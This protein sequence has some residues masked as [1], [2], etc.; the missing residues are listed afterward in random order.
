MWMI[1][2]ANIYFVLLA[3]SHANSGHASCSWHEMLSCSTAVYRAMQQTQVRLR[4]ILLALACVACRLTTCLP[5]DN[6]LSA[7]LSGTLRCIN[8][9]HWVLACWQLNL[10]W[11]QPCQMKPGQLALQSGSWAW[12]FWWRS[13]QATLYHKHVRMPCCIHACMHVNK[14]RCCWMTWCCKCQQTLAS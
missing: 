7:M 5:K 4:S 13:W 9:A 10:V 3:Q 8:V 11:M 14:T 12:H 2:T 1:T 6:T